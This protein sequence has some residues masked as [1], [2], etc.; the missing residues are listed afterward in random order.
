[1]VKVVVVSVVQGSVGRQGGG[2]TQPLN[3]C[4]DLELSA[5]FFCTSG[6]VFN[7]HLFVNYIT[8]L[9]FCHHSP[10][11]RFK[12]L[13]S[14]ALLESVGRTMTSAAAASATEPTPSFS[15]SSAAASGNA[16][17]T[18]LAG[19]EGGVLVVYDCAW[20]MKELDRQGLTWNG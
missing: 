12:D 3:I 6:Y 16:A 4:S 20:L 8:Y 1:M 2:G 17:T 18:T 14:N 9:C 15:S 7:F 13:P 11:V 5:P 10:Q 19:N